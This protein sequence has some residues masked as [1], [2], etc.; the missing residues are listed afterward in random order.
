MLIVH[1]PP[2]QAATPWA[3][4]GR[5]N[6]KEYTGMGW[7]LQPTV[8]WWHLT[9]ARSSE[10]CSIFSMRVQL[11]LLAARVGSPAWPDRHQVWTWCDRC[12]ISIRQS[13]EYHM[14]LHISRT[15]AVGTVIH[16]R[17]VYRDWHI[18]QH[19]SFYVLILPAGSQCYWL[20]HTLTTDLQFTHSRR[21]HAWT[22]QQRYIRT[23]K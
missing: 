1:Q 12:R 22:S 23:S 19:P 4:D 7:S 9:R 13:I 21:Q 6:G 2:L 16:F 5:T 14:W 15:A 17:L 18:F 3:W 10:C 20:G 11:L 8:N